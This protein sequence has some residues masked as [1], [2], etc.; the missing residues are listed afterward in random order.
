MA[1]IRQSRPEGFHKSRRCSRHTY[2][3]SYITKY[4]QYTKK[5]SFNP[6]KLFALRLA[7]GPGKQL[8]KGMPSVQ[9]LAQ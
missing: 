5:T 4:T 3:E 1:H 2:P 6:F 9:G 8:E 7:A